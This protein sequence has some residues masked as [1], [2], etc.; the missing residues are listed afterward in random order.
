MFKTVATDIEEPRFTDPDLSLVQACL[1]G[2]THG[3]KMQQLQR[4][5][6]Y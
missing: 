6:N 4:I 2:D 3:F 1:Q 5:H